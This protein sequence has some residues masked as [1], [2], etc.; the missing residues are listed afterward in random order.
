MLEVYGC[1]R[2]CVLEPWHIMLSLILNKI[3]DVLFSQRRLIM[4]S[5]VLYGPNIGHKYFEI[6]F[7]NFIIL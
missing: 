7:F 4:H 5:M 2:R 6:I 1:V 3:I